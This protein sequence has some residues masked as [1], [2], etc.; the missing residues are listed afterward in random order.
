M[1][2]ELD[3]ISMVDAAGVASLLFTTEGV[4]VEFPKEEKSTA[5]DMP[6]PYGG[7]M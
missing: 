4:V 6:N 3:E 7:M 2:D 5:G 1:F